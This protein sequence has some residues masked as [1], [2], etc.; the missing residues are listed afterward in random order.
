MIS[1]NCTEGTMKKISSGLRNSLI[2]E[3]AAKLWKIV[4]VLEVDDLSFFRQ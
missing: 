2:S 3:K 1:N 4:H